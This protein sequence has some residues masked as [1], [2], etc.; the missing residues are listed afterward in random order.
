MPVMPN[1]NLAGNNDAQGY[2][3]YW[4]LA[5]MWLTF[6]ISTIA[7]SLIIPALVEASI[8]KR[9]QLT[10]LREKQL[11]N[12][13]LIGIATLAAGTAHDMGTP[14]MTMEILLNDSLEHQLDLKQEDRE[15]LHL[16][17][18]ICRQALQRLSLAG[19]NIHNKTQYINAYQWLTSLL[20]R[21]L[22]KSA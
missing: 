9:L 6:V 19:R 21:L 2:C 16:Q 10:E 12:G 15:L 22:L 18:M 4:H 20:Q 5:G 1:H 14:L 3:I 17:V 8:K 7:L 11:K 13:Q